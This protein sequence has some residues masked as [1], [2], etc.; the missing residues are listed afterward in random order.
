MYY[1]DYHTDYHTDAGLMTA[2][3][4]EAAK[5]LADKY[6][7]YTQEGITIVD[8]DG[9][10]VAVRDWSWHT[11][12]ADFDDADPIQFGDRGFYH[13]WCD[14]GE[15]L[16]LFYRGERRVVYEGD[17]FWLSV[18]PINRVWLEDEASI[19]HLVSMPEEPEGIVWSET[20]G[21]VFADGS[22]LP[23]LDD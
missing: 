4:L 2:D 14:S 5:A 15:D 7:S 12:D 20:I 6:A 21:W 16:S 3:T 13:D 18:D 19:S 9:I 17:G 8:A 22:A 23:W 1:I 10:A 11:F